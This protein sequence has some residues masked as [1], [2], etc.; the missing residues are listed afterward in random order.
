MYGLPT[1]TIRKEFRTKVVPSNGLNPMYNEE[2]FVFRKVQS[3][4]NADMCKKR[5]KSFAFDFTDRPTRVGGAPVRRLRRQQQQDA[6]SA[7]PA[8]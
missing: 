2:P 4:Q 8:F 1:D 6:G 3:S 7:N 5:E